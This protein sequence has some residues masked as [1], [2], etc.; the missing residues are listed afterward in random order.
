MTKMLRLALTLLFVAASLRAFASAPKPFAREDIASDVVRLTETLRKQTIGIGAAL[1]DRSGDQL[2]QAASAAAASSDYKT[3]AQDIAGAIAATPKDATAWL[4]LARLGQAADDAKAEG[5]Y[6]LLTHATTAAYAAYQ[7]AKGAPAQAEALATLGNLEARNESWRIALDAY[8]ASLARKDDPDVRATYEDLRE[9]H[10]FRILDY[11]V[12][13]EAAN[14]RVCFNFSDPLQRKIDFSPYVAVAGATNAAISNEDQQLCVEG[15]KH[16]ERYAVVLRQGLPSTVGESL[17]KDADYEIYV[18]DRSPQAHFVGR[19][20]VLPRLGQLGAP[21]TTVNTAKVS[22]DVY[23][24]GDRNLLAEIAGDDFLKPISSARAA[25]IEQQDGAKVWSGAM[26]VASELN[27]D[28]VTDFPLNAAIGKLQPGLYLVTAKPW[29]PPKPIGAEEDSVDQLATQWMVISD[30]GL[31]ALSGADGVHAIVRSLSTAAPLAGVALRLLARNNEVLATKTTDAEGRVDF[32]PGLSRGVGGLAPALLVATLADD[33]GFLNLTQAAFDLTD[34]GVA[35]RD[36]PG[37]LDAFLYTER[38]VYRSGETVYVAALL[39][40]AKGAAKPGLALTL[41][42]KRP[43]GVE[44]KRATIAD[45]GLGGRSLALPLAVGAMAGTWSIDAYADPKAPAIGHAQFLLEDYVPERLDYQLK[46]GVAFAVSGEPIPISLDARFLYGAPAAGLDVTGAIRLKAVDGSQL[47]G[48]PGYVAG[49]VDETFD[50]IEVQFPEKRQTDDK[51]HADLSI[52]LPESDAVKPLEA[53][54]IVDVAESGGRT[55]ERTLTLPVRSKAVMIGVKKDFGDDL[56]SGESARFEAIA[57][58]P[59]GASLPRKGVTW[60]LYK[61]SNDY[62]WFNVDG[63]WNF[64]PVKSSRKLADGTFDINGGAP[65]RFSAIVGWGQHRLDV[66]SA[67]GEITSFTFDVGWSGTA[68]ADTP[69][70]A[71]VTLDKDN[72]AP[73]ESAKLNITSRFAGKATIALVGVKLEQMIDIDLHEGENVVPFTVGGDWGAG[74]YAVAITQRPLDVKQKRMP[75]RAMGVAWFS[76]DEAAHKL[77]VSINAPPKTR[78]RESVRIPIVLAGLSAGEEA[79]VTVAA[80]DIGI[81]NLT[82]YQTPDPSS[83]F[84]GQR[85]LALDVRDLYGFLIDGMQGVAGALHV[86][87]DGGGSLEGNLPTQ[88]PLAL[89]SGV[90]RVGADGKAEIPFDLPSFNGAVR[91]TAVAWTGAK[92]GAASADMIVRDPVVVTASL[93]RFLNI[94]D[95]S[96]LQFDIDNVEGEAGDYRLSLD[97]HGPVAAAA[98][99]LTRTIKLAAHQK[100]KVTIPIEANGVGTAA[101]DLDVT[102]PG[103]SAP[104]SFALGVTAG[105]PDIYARSFTD[106]APGQTTRIDDTSLKDFVPGTGSL[107]LS[108]SPFG[109]IDAPAV[110]QA[111][112]R[113]PYGCSEQ[114]VSRAMP[115][116]YANK[117]ASAEHLAIDPDLDGRIKAA[118]DKQ[119]TRQST[120]GAFGLW[121]AD[122]EGDDLW[123]DAFVADFLTRARE[124]GFAVPQL[125]FDNALDH[126]RNTAVNAS[127][128]G[129]GAAV[130]YALY[131]L[132]RN[133]RPVIGDLRY[134]VGAKLDTFKTPMARAQLGAALAMLGDRARAGRAFDAALTMLETQQASLLS[135][136]DYGSKLRDA[137]AVLALLAESRLDAD[138]APPDGLARASAV[139]DAARDATDYVSTQENNW[140]A[141]AA[142]AL[143]ERQPKDTITIDGKPVAGALYRRWQAFSVGAELATIGNNGDTPLKLVTTISGAPLAP[144]PAAAHGYEIARSFYTLDGKPADINS[145][146]QNQRIVV[147]LRITEAAAQ[148]AKLLVVD[149]LPAGLEIDNPALFDSGSTAAFGWLKRDIEPVHVEYRDDRFV[150]AI[151]REVGQSAFFSLAYIV[152]ATTPGHYVY[153]A[154]TAQDMYRPSRFGRTAFGEVEVKAR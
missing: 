110:L 73:G 98:D 85:K 95:R 115:L 3:A 66:K 1:K 129:D 15:L 25:A 94:G 108:V 41:I 74:A 91:I 49:L 55:V 86:G 83:Y 97:I 146:T 56:S 22:V 23:R 133:G 18:K 107:S 64:E 38:G 81:L 14:P 59:D 2:L 80:V 100:S 84:F 99:A 127:D 111:L 87:G 126:L 116:L 135:R 134:L 53:R 31:T 40:D 89:F 121:S 92:V 105:A 109:A 48:H 63:R 39:R 79:R 7:Y 76:I 144:E 60:S 151:D 10:G 45:Q 70:N 93:P 114:V 24:V 137:A 36:A 21:L 82:H 139:L 44:Y 62:Q 103:F 67:E 75:A 123:L 32:D 131:V 19:A 117:L 65:A 101:L 140:L 28:V 124:R 145:L 37:P 143:A 77:A 26:D 6:E 120:N 58:A 69:D 30:L 51:G 9:K 102:G 148:Y 57:V 122:T 112:E 4:A 132:A 33:Y 61:L 136:P 153:P 149:P 47:P 150:A 119:M 43:D 154:A 71:V 96:R 113:Y 130:A 34:R 29:T 8:H 68:S 20:Y 12:D 54:V 142:E 27:K 42:V 90:V 147:V 78:P 5:R 13:N 118:I 128:P 106:L 138:D 88:A 46:A 125:G 104:Q 50:P 141:L 152:R 52:E 35:G 17:L 16:G 11:K 72:Y